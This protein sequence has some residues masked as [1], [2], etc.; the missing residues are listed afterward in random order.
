MIA[1]FNGAEIRCTDYAPYGTAELSMLAVEGLGPRH[2]V[3]LGSHGMIVVGADL[4]QAMW[5]AV[6]LETLA[7]CYYL[8]RA[9]GEPVVLPDEEIEALI[10]RFAA[11]G[12][13]GA[14]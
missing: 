11:Y 9:Q 13:K 2:G 12:A 4:E 5:R 3:L 8:A 6:E 14:R 7:R 1:A 10:P